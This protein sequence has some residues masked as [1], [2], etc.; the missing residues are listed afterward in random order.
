MSQHASAPEDARSQ[1]QFDV[2]KAV[3]TSKKDQIRIPSYYRSQV[4]F[5]C[6]TGREDLLSKHQS[7]SSM[8]LYRKASAGCRK[9]Q[10]RVQAPGSKGKDTTLI[11]PWPMLKEP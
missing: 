8:L 9:V 3:D 5:C 6:D 11:I 4:Q 2:L 10:A 1:H 7:R